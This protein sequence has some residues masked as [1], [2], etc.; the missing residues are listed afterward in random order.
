M[1]V[2]PASSSGFAQQNVKI[3]FT[4][5]AGHHLVTTPQTQLPLFADLRLPIG[6]CAAPRIGVAVDAARKGCALLAR[7]K[8]RRRNAPGTSQPGFC[9]R[10]ALMDAAVQS[11]V[12]NS[13]QAAASRIRP[14]EPTSLT[15]PA[16]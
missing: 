11:G 6:G 3:L 14:V 8:I 5:D 10:A 1:A 16:I 4:G 15:S 13:I 7:A 2:F 9:N 12:F